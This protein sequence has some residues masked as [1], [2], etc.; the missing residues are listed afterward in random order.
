M[1]RDKGFGFI[2]PDNA[3]GE[4]SDLFFH[5]SS[6]DNQ[7]FDMLEEGQRVEFDEEPDPRNASRRRAANVTVAGA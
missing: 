6:V 7:G 3:Q 5:Q 2:A 4:G 1:L